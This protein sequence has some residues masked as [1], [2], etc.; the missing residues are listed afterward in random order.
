MNNANSEKS[1]IEKMRKS[2]LIRIIYCFVWT[3]RKNQLKN[4]VSDINQNCK[5]NHVNSDKWIFEDTWSI[6]Q[7][8]FGDHVRFH[9]YDV[10]EYI[11]FIRTDHRD[12]TDVFSIS[13]N[14]FQN[15]DMVCMR[16]DISNDHR[17]ADAYFQL[18]HLMMIF[19]V[20]SEIWSYSYSS[21]LRRVILYR[22]LM[23]DKT[24]IVCFHL[25]RDHVIIDHKFS[26]FFFFP[27]FVIIKSSRDSYSSRI[28]VIRLRYCIFFFRA[29]VRRE[30]LLM[31]CHEY[32]IDAIRNTINDPNHEQ[33]PK[34]TQRFFI[35]I[36]GKI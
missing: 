1:V 22:T 16:L 9:Q 34:L 11:S 29:R 4:Q 18:Y 23:T 32:Q 25:S 15:W 20:S 8:I 17:W 14:S 10:D 2:N 13:V 3:I 6:Y 5:E 31:S 35:A 12:D 21:S 27:N 26:N 30:A 33:Y 24:A 36:W 19:R 28:I 7:T